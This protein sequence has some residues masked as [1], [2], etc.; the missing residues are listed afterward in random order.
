M[1]DILILVV[2]FMLLLIYHILSKVKYFL[3]GKKRIFFRYFLA[4]VFQFQIFD[5]LCEQAGHKGPLHLCDLHGSVAAGK[6]LKY[7]CI[8]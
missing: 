1:N 3:I 6:K 7:I 5:V 2:N 8:D 4:H